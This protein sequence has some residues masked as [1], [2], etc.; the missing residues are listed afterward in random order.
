VG[1]ELDQQGALQQRLAHEPEVEVLEVAQA[2]VDQL[3]RAAR[4]AGRE[5]GPLHERDAVAARG[6]VERHPGARDAPADHDQVERVPF[7]CGERVGARDH[8]RNVT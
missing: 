4:G 7:E 2:A 5:V 6:R 1:R 3:R 8:G